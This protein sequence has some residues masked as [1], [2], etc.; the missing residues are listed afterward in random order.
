MDHL[1]NRLA[2]L[3]RQHNL[4]AL[5]IG[6]HAVTAHG[7]PRATFDVDLVV[8]RGEAD[9]WVEALD[10]LG[11][12][13]GERNRNFIQLENS[14]FYGTPPIDFMLVEKE[15]FQRLDRWKSGKGVIPVP[16]V[17]AIIAMKLHAIRQPAREDVEKDWGD[18]MA[19]I[20]L[21]GLT[22]DADAFSAMVM[23]HG[24]KEGYEKIRRELA[25]GD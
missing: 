22:L 12:R 25:G 17:E 6:G 4:P 7:H 10:E 24:G 2:E 8:P 11:Y 18:V 15:V 21:H 23:K 9:R 1:L 14:V 20:R 3:M 16:S 19:L 5:L 13:V